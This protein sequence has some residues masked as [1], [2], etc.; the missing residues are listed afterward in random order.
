MAT[1]YHTPMNRRGRIAS[2]DYIRVRGGT[3]TRLAI[4]LDPVSVPSVWVRP[5]GAATSGVDRGVTSGHSVACLS[6]V[7]ARFKTRS[8]D[9]AT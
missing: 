3:R 9:E 5:V 2:A 6:S 4:R 7:E 8:R 1:P